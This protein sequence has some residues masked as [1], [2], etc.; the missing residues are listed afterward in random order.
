MKPSVMLWLP[1]DEQRHG[2]LGLALR[3]RSLKVNAAT[4]DHLLASSR[5]SYGMGRV[6]T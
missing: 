6:S 4:I 5:F 2:K 3:Q 1:N